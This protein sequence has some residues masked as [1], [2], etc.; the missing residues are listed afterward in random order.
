[1]TGTA[2]D[3]APRPAAGWEE[4]LAAAWS[5]AGRRGLLDDPA[6]TR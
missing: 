5:E 4:N 1:M 3:P 6:A 2:D